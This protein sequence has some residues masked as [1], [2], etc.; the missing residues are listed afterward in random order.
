[1]IESDVKTYCMETTNGLSQRAAHSLFLMTDYNF[2]SKA[3]AVTVVIDLQA[4]SITT[5]TN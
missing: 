1:M 3:V 2:Y 5:L 4:R